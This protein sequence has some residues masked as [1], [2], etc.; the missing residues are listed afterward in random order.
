MDF[1][2]DLAALDQTELDATRQ[3]I[4]SALEDYAP[5]AD[6]RQGAIHD[7]VLELNAV[8]AQ[9]SQEKVNKAE[10][11]LGVLALDDAST[12][13]PAA[14]DAVLA[15]YGVK[16]RVATPAAGSAQ[17]VLSAFMP[18]TIQA[19]AVFTAGGQSYQSV[20]TFQARTSPSL[21]S[22]PTDRLI[23]QLSST[24]WVFTIDLVCAVTGS[25][26]ALPAGAQ[27][28]PAS[29][30]AN[31][32]ECYSRESFSGGQDQETNASLVAR[33]Q[34]GAAVKSPGNRTSLEGMVRTYIPEA[35]HVSATGAGDAAMLRDKHGL[36]PGATGGKCD[37]YLRYQGA[38]EE[39]TLTVTATLN[40]KVGAVGTWQVGLT[41]DQAAGLYEVKKAL[42]PTQAFSATG[43]AISYD[44]RGVDVSGESWPPDLASPLE[45]TYSSYQTVVVRFADTITDVT[46][47]ST[48][49]TASY[50]L[51]LRRMPKIKELQ[52]W[53]SAAERR[54]LA[55]DLLIKS[56]VPV[57]SAVSFDLVLPVS[58]PTPDAS[59]LKAAVASAVAGQGFSARLSASLVASGARA[60]SPLA[61]VDNVALS[62]RL[63][64]PDAT[65]V[66]LSGSQSL[67][68]T[69]DAANMTTADTVIFFLVSAD[70]TYTLVRV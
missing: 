61:A 46:S 23:T 9:L 41:R 66:S 54:P 7:L 62:G 6:V 38:Y 51:V 24:R 18:V 12:A 52:A 27:L 32:V 21:V 14:V 40:S 45:A 25:A 31:F 60:V 49:A 30:P 47:V 53:F 4:L 10:S 64:K 29:P 33:L 28:T 16:R 70:V 13:D 8:L 57:F 37:L 36:F 69:P 3:A 17:V 56:P 65:N 15:D 20:S 67:A 50:V 39:S 55:S 26:G 58:A 1:V 68:I 48:G 63:R 59:A 34:A 5:T 35:L 44:A 42:L 43:F 19:G 11:A 2:Y 22:L